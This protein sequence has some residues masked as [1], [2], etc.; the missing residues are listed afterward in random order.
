MA[1]IRFSTSV[2]LMFRE[3][4]ML[5]RF[6]AARAAGFIGVEIQAL[7]EGDP[8]AMAASA[9]AA[10]VTVV[11]VNVPMADFRDGGPGL[12][13]VPGREPQFEAA[14]HRALDA[15]E[16][17]GARLVH[18]GPSRV[19]IGMSRPAS[20]AVYRSNLEMALKAADGRD[21]QLLI[22]PLNTVEFPEVLLSDLE[23]AATF[24]HA[25]GVDRLGLQFDIFHTAMNGLDPRAAFAAHLRS[26]RHI[27]F[28]DAPGRHEPGTGSIDF[29]GIFSDIVASGYQGWVGAEYYP[30]RR[31]AE[32]FGWLDTLGA[33]FGQ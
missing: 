33:R 15:A 8:T 20:V 22:E 24:V 18:V 25:V 4:P 11:L 9:K 3:H 13:G 27:Q 14:L 7:D 12:S 21:I 5:E 23:E 10:G 19:P 28:S 1:P 16:R 30:S 17:L 32:T 26:I 31:T 6:G 2:S 29:D